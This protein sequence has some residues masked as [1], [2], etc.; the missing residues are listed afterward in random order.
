M[1]PYSFG[2]IVI[3]ADFGDDDVVNVLYEGGVDDASFA[4]RDGSS[5]A[6]FDREA[7]SFPAALTSAIRDLES[8]LPG[9]KVCGLHAEDL[10]TPAG[11]AAASKRTRQSVHQH[12]QGERGTGFPP[13]LTWA[14][15]D[16]PLWL[17]S[18]VC[19]WAGTAHT[20]EDRRDHH[21]PA[22]AAGIFHLAR[23]SASCGH[24]RS[25][26]QPAVAM[27]IERY[28]AFSASASATRLELTRHLRELA[29]QLEHDEFSIVP[30]SEH[31]YSES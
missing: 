12:I 17:R 29:D 6:Y 1:R 9:L 15:R 28:L 19:D 10:L 13:P 16:R 3:G 25:G 2:L 31:W 4:V 5:V 23:A 27:L 18:D 7:D 14:D 20:D 21:W 24:E 11:V 30:R 8:A 26:I 22:V